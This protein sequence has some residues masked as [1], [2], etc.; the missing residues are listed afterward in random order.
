M[1]QS[2]KISLSESQRQLIEVWGRLAYS[3][4][5]GPT[6]AQIFALLYVHPEPLDSDTI[7]ELLAISRGNVS[8][9]LRKLIEWGLIRK[10]DIP[11][12]RRSLYTAER[13]IWVIAANIVKK[14]FEREIAPIQ[15][16]LEELLAR[17]DVQ[18]DPHTHTALL[19]IREV[20]SAVYLVTQLAI[21]VMVAAD[22]DRFLKIL[23]YWQKRFTD[24]GNLSGRISG[25]HPK[26]GRDS[27]PT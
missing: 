2:R 15:T 6:M 4:G 27:Q 10:I 17:P 19:Q 5:I 18:G 21:P 23:S 22:R 7:L 12:S 20:V 16:L 24:G 9:N 3:W 25:S 13:D 1:Y 11:G 14:R 26:A 8:I